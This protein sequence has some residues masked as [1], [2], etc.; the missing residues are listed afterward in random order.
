MSFKIKI[1]IYTERGQHFSGYLHGEHSSRDSA[2]LTQRV[3]LHDLAHAADSPSV[4][5]STVTEGTL[6]FIPATVLKSSVIV[7][8]IEEG[9]SC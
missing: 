9:K 2:E 7:L 1:E 8:E 3:T 4:T 6:I 5:L